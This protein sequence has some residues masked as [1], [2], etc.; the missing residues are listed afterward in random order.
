[1]RRYHMTRAIV[2]LAALTLLLA[3]C[4]T[5]QAPGT[6]GS[7]TRTGSAPSASSSPPPPSGSAALPSTVPTPAGE[8]FTAATVLEKPGAGVQ[9]CL[10]AVATSLPPQ[11]GGPVIDN[12][13]WA[14]APKH[15]SAAGVT[16]GEYVVIGRYDPG[17]NRFHVTRTVLTMESAGS[18]IPKPPDPVDGFTTPCPVPEGGWRV[19]DPATTTVESM[20]ETLVAAQRIP[21]YA[22]SW[23]DQSPNHADPEKEPEKMNDPAKLILNV[24]VTRDSAAAEASL[25]KTWGGM[26][27]VSE[28]G[29][30][31]AELRRVQDQLPRLWQPSIATSVDSRTSTLDFE[32]AYDDGTIQRAVDAKYGT[33]AVRV[34]GQ[35]Q[36]YPG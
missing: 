4:G 25:R 16:W 11:C 8:V 24:K 15:E 12:W 23:L 22:G 21:G 6:S 18:L 36:P 7:A 35:L 17:A 27:C 5:A 3:A 33:G 29:R 30:S 31:E 34:T 13:D 14:T 2:P 26:L 1:M 10:G 19:L 28:G 32:V 9:L 20:D